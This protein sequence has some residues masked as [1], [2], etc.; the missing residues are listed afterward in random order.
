MVD[1]LT[2]YYRCPERFIRFASKEALSAHS[3]YFQ[4]GE[5]LACF[6]KYYGHQPSESAEGIGRD[7]WS[8]IEIGDGTTYLPFDPSELVD[9]LRF[10][11]Y[12][13]D[14]QHDKLYSAFSKMYY[15]I[16]PILS[17]SIRKQLQKI[18]LSGW[19][20]M[21]F[22]HWPVDTSVDDLLQQ[23]FLSAIRSSGVEQIPFIWFWPESAPSCVLMT[24]DVEGIAGRD[25]CPILMDINDSLGIKESFGVIP[26][27]RYPMSPEF[28][29]SIRDRGF[30]VVVHDL[31]HDGRL[32]TTRKQ[33]LERV[34]KINAYGR[35]YG[36]DGFRAGVPYRKQACYDALDFACNMSVPNVAH[37]DP[38]LVVYCTVMPYFIGT[39]LE[40]P[41]IS[42]RAYTL[43]N[44]LKEHSTEL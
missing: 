32:Y 18:Y 11:S 14:W 20:K 40:L 24:H 4:L 30:E 39:I 22:P 33:F 36:A 9:N 37:L 12:A 10:E 28:L 42:T 13:G 15:L 43:F 3:G 25:F 16:R 26:E 2:Q 7:S 35:E 44:I 31:N 29:S 5:R 17:V 38:Q 27:Q 6:G 23:L 8:D 21:P 1:C 41:V 34:I 19:D